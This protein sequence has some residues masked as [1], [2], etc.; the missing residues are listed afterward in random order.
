M[1]QLLERLSIC[2][3]M[4]EV[5][6]GDMQLHIGTLVNMLGHCSSSLILLSR[7]YILKMKC[8]YRQQLPPTSFEV[9]IRRY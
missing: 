5:V 1:A 6:K 9:C 2:Y 7:L 8:K 3:L 4:L